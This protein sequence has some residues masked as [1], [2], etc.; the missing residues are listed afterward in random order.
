MNNSSGRVVFFFFGDLVSGGFYPHWIVINIFILV[1]AV[2]SVVIFRNDV[3]LH[4]ECVCLR[5]IQRV[6]GC[7]CVCVVVFVS[8]KRHMA[9]NQPTHQ[10]HTYTGI[11]VWLRCYRR[12]YRCFGASTFVSCFWVCIGSYRVCVPVSL[13]VLSFPCMSVFVCVSV[14]RAWIFIRFCRV[15]LCFS[16]KMFQLRQPTHVRI[17]SN[18]IHNQNIR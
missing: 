3:P 16:F 5:E 6:C 8:C 18:C 2:N 17:K 1:C 7:G 4:N 13:P 9:R 15:F 10:I 12:T 14:K 11:R